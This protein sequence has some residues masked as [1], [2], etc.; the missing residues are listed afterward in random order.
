L[1]SFILFENHPYLGRLVMPTVERRPI[2]QKTVTITSANKK[3]PKW[4]SLVSEIE[5]LSKDGMLALRPDD[6]DSMR[7]LKVQVARAARAA[8][9][10]D[11]VLYGESESGE[12]EVWLRDRPR[13]M[14]PVKGVNR[15]V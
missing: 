1:L 6:G 8:G 11:E 15:D 3:R 12:L 7:A 4:Q 14:S 13:R 9:R 2:S 10:Q 5:E